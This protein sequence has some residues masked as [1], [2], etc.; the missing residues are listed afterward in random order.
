METELIPMLDS[1]DYLNFLLDV[2]KKFELEFSA[3]DLP[4]LNTL[5][6]VVIIVHKA[7]NIKN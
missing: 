1:I 5:G 6:D 4:T 3:S 7:I 2:K